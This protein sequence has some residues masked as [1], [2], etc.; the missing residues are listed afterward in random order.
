M[1]ATNVAMLALLALPALPGAL[2]AQKSIAVGVYTEEQA[3]RGQ[4]TFETICSECHKREWFAGDEFKEHWAY[5]ELFWV[6]DF[7]RRNMPYEAAGTLAPQ[8]YRD[9]VAYILKLRG[10]KAGTYELPTTDE[11]WMQLVFPPDP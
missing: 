2:Q 7:V 9:V 4:D 5:G 11:G 8:T 6:Y 1:K 3:K 10:F